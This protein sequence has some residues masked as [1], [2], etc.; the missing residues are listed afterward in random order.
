MPK[1]VIIQRVLPH[2]RI[3]FFA[4]LAE[5]LYRE[6]VEMKLVYGQEYPGTVPKTTVVEKAWAHRIRNRYLR[7][8]GSEAV[9]Q[10]CLNQLS[11]CDLVIVEQS[12]RLV[13]NYH[14]MVGRKCGKFKLAYWGHGRNLQS[15]RRGG[16][17]ERLK[18]KLI[19]AV[20]WWFAYTALSA[21]VVRESG[22]PPDRITVVQNAVSTRE[23]EEQ[24]RTVTAD[25]LVAVRKELGIN[26][27]NVAV[28]CGGMYPDKKLDF[29]VEACDVIRSKI[30]DFEVILVGEG[31]D[32]HIVERAASRHP[33]LHYV[34]ARYGADRVV[35]L[36]SAKLLLM[37]GL[38]GLAVVD[39]FAAQVPLFTTDIPIHSPEIAYLEN[40]VNGVMTAADV[41]AYAEAVVH[42][43]GHRDRLE[44]LRQGC[45]ASSA[46]YTVENMIENFAAGIVQCLAS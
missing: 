8:P 17:R 11:D 42:Y 41:D 40:G 32:Q 20:D 10:P 45:R 24:V 18:Q 46:K 33:W 28:Y 30:P 13:V 9:W 4:G 22:F 35:F 25:R 2:Y 12:N 16:L 38:V 37:P 23:I 19:G 14:L 26:S 43:L 39:S 6:G 21:D 36:L 1:V 27:G 34:G 15:G 7:F 3:P 5:R 44:V 31:P 29:L